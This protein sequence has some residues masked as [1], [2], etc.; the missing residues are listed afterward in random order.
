MEPMDIERF[1][2]MTTSER[3]K[4]F[5]RLSQ[6][7]KRWFLDHGDPVELVV[8]GYIDPTAPVYAQ[9]GQV[10]QFPKGGRHGV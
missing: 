10:L 2:A 1:M 6:T 9:R 7:D 8:C 5:W 4:H 3:Q